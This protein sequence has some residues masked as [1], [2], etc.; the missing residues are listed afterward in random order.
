MPDIATLSRPHRK[1]AGLRI[2]PHAQAP[3]LG[4][5]ITKMVLRPLVKG[6]DWL[7]PLEP[8]H[9]L[10]PEWSADGAWIAL[11]RATDKGTELWLADVEHRALKQITDVRLNAVLG[12]PVTWMHDQRTLL[13]KLSLD[14]KESASPE[15]PAGPVVQE[16]QGAKAQVRTIQDLLQ[17]E[18]DAALFDFHTTVQLALI[19]IDGTKR[20]IGRPA[21]IASA[22]PSPDDSVLLVSTVERP[23]SYLVAWENFPRRVTL[24][25]PDGSTLQSVADLPLQESVPIGGVPTGPRSIHWL[26]TAPATLCWAEALDGG[27][28]KAKVTHRDQV[29][30]MPAG[31]AAREWLRTEHRFQSLE[32][33]EDGRLAL[34]T[35]LD[36]DTRKQRV[37]QLDAAQPD[38]APKLLLERSTQDA[39]GDPGNPVNRTNA[40]GITAVRQTEGA[41]YLS[42]A[43]ASKDG[44][45][46]F[47]DR[48]DIAT[49]EK[50]RVFQSAAE[51]YE[52]FAGFLDDKG[53]RILISSE[54]AT[55]TA[56]YLALDLASG[57]RTRLTEFTSPAADYAS[58]SQRVL[59]RYTRADGVPLSGQLHLPPGWTRGKKL[60]VLI[61]AY[62]LEYNQASDAGQVRGSPHRFMKL[63]GASHLWLVAAGYAV[64]DQASMP[65]VGPVRSANDTFIQQLVWNAEAAVDA[66]VKHGVGER[67]NMAVAGHS[68]GAFMT[69]N[70]LCHSDVF[71]TGIAR[72]GGYNRTLT[73]FGFQNED[74]TYW[75]A[76]ALYQAMSPF[77][78]ADKLR[79]P[80]LLIH[81]ADD[82]NAGTFPM[83]SQRLYAAI[84]GNGGSA[85]LVILPHEGHEYRAAESVQHCLREMLDW[86]DRHLKKP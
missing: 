72:S 71:A 65:I 57:Q 16:T 80:I 41:I 31:G 7:L 39:Y 49:G 74:R 46:P 44:E 75:E 55:E 9:W 76:P 23:F 8:G 2:D 84:K 15:R 28:P 53:A 1:L 3:Q 13:C 14:G 73:P 20:H 10:A 82:E 32:V 81:G 29:R 68:Y 42:G 4:A 12:K 85:R 59:L 21:R 18:H 77:A 34:L 67:G 62:P 30:L 24:M 86:L 35:E 47:L 38:A 78:N 51:R 43:G 54:S 37:W 19:G 58:K 33:A 26:P 64:L 17:N 25:R 52:G 6:E 70:L 45:R 69:A 66:L 40:R 50:K 60:P 5:H 22:Q 83:Q 61:W 27:N 63:R 79:K 48:W 56:N 11:P 36:R